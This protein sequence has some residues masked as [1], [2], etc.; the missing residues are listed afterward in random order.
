M[1][2]RQI[3]SRARNTLGV[4]FQR[5]EIRQKVHCVIFVSKINTMELWKLANGYGCLI[6]NITFTGITT[7]LLATK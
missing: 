6:V 7:T 3:W 2:H 1:S 4:G 5:S